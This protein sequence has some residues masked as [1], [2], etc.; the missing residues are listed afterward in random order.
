MKSRSDLWLRALNELGAQCS[1]NTTHDAE[2]LVRRA[3]Q[4]GS[5]F[6]TTT[7]PRFG[8]DFERSLADGCIPTDAFTGFKRDREGRIPLFLSGFVDLALNGT[9]AQQHADSMASSTSP[10][11]VAAKAVYAVRQ[12]CFMFYKEKELC[13]DDLI[14]KA[15]SQY[16]EVDRSISAPLEDSR[17]YLLFEGGLLDEA[18]KLVHLMF[19]DVLAQVEKDIYEG[20]LAPGH[21]PGATADHLYG[22]QKW[23]LPS[24]TDRL[25]T[26][27][28]YLDYA[29]PN[30]RY[31]MDL[32][33]VQFLSPD[34]ELP[35]KLT[36]VAKTQATPRLIAIEPTCMQYVQQAIAKPLV[37]YIE[38]DP[39]AGGYVGFTD[40]EPNRLL[41]CA[42]SDTGLLAT[43]DLSEA[44]DRVANWLVEDLFAGFPLFLEAIQACRST[45][46]RLPDGRIIGLQK[47]ASMGSALTF[48]IEA[49]TFVIVSLLG[50]IK[51]S[52]LP[53]TRG[54]IQEFQGMVRV[55]GD[56]IVVPSA[57]AE[58][59]IEYLETFGFKVNRSKSF[60]TGQFRESCGAEFYKGFDVSIVKVRKKLPTSRRDV[61]SII[62][63]VASRNLFFRGGLVKT[64]EFIDG[65]MEDLLRGF[66][67][68]VSETS[69]VLGRHVPE[70]RYQVDGI[71]P[72][73]HAP[74]VKGFVVSAKNPINEIDGVPALMKCILSSIGNADVDEDHLRRS[75]R[76]RVV[77]IKLAKASPF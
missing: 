38:S 15:V 14:N 71:T 69:A 57:H 55:Y 56:D 39:L 49:M 45:R 53:L 65:I 58:T 17:Q 9:V 5:S 64:A 36:A 51:G 52:N 12:L 3:T 2:T 16:V 32:N 37:R 61:D 54:S 24:W 67:P 68:A 48:P 76:P 35:V 43:L 44:S 40:Q 77:S 46:V 60:W 31:W 47:F 22:N 59:V 42:G 75:G 74:F 19:G 26:L 70:D 41:A 18:R 66:Y 62:S 73:T 23:T 20:N 27:F 29:L 50:L 28:P 30:Y 6:L 7:L 8:K 34:D 25:E 72:A 63:T 21:G 13:S 10:D 11:E 4:E 1:V 33:E